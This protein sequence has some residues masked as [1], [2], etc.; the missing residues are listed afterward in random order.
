MIDFFFDFETRSRK[1]LKKVGSVVYA[2]D[3]STE[4][5]LITWTF[6]RTAPVKAWRKGTPIPQELIHV[7]LNPEKYHF[8]AHNVMF[9]FLIWTQVFIKNI[10]LLKA[11]K[12]ENISDNMAHTSYFRVG[13]SLDAAAK[14][15]QLPMSKDKD[16]RKLMLKQCKPDSKGN[17]IELTATEWASFEHYGKIDT[18]L[19]RKIYYSIPP[20]PPSERFAWEWTFKRNLKGLK[21]DMDVVNLLSKIV[22]DSTPA[23]VKE[24]E[25]ITGYRVK[26]N[27]PIQCK[28]Y[29]KQ[30]FPE[31][32]DMQADTLRDMIA[33]P[34]PIPAH[35]RRA[36]EI[37]DLAGGAS[38]SKLDAAIRMNYGGRIYG[39]LAYAH[40]QTKRWAGRGIQVHNFPRVD[41]KRPDDIDFDLNVINLAEHIAAKIPMLKDPMGFAKNLLRRI[42]LPDSFDLKFYCGDWSKIEPTVLFW[43]TGLGEIPDDWYE[44]MASTIYGVPKSTIGKESEERQLGKSAA[45]GCGY[46]MGHDKFKGDTL[47]KTGIEISIELSKHAVNSYRKKYYPITNLWRQLEQAFKAAIYGQPTNLCDGKIFVLPMEKPHSGVKIRLPSGSYIYYHGARIIPSTTYMSEGE[48]VT[49][50]PGI[51]YLLDENG[52]PVLK[53]VY[54]G[55]LTEHI[56]SGTARDIIVP[57]LYN[58]EVAGF[59]ILNTVHDELWGQGAYGRDKEFEDIMCIRPSWC[60]DMKITAGMKNGIRYLK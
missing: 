51:A 59:D 19:L 8:I 15:L 26:I 47:K 12:I 54:G 18:E 6:G 55:L 43:L 41:E 39:N 35:V 50:P 14:I 25:H 60:K 44:D 30:F 37:K 17:F 9:D 53:K 48:I 27:S 34:R 45:L 42:F 16:G 57:A 3:S 24:F 33:D 31:I 20:L 13:A 11:P 29:F 32:E 7:A 5:T 21:L 58:L 36:L 28:E 4:A 38:L 2:T 46:G 10:P 22:I 52:S 23:Y 56:T 49:T 40:A 1:D